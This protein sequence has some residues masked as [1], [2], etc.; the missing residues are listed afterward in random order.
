MS[1]QS[2]QEMVTSYRKKMRAKRGPKQANTSNKLIS[3]HQNQSFVTNQ[4]Y[5][6]TVQHNSVNANNAEGNLKPSFQY[7]NQ[8][9][10]NDILLELQRTSEEQKTR[11]QTLESTIDDLYAKYNEV[12]QIL[13]LA[14]QTGTYQYQYSNMYQMNNAIPVPQSFVPLS[15]PQGFHPVP[16]GQTIE[17]YQQPQ[18][19]FSNS[20]NNQDSNSNLSMHKQQIITPESNNDSSQNPVTWKP[21]RS[22]SELNQSVFHKSDDDSE[23]DEDSYEAPAPKKLFG[24]K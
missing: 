10:A 13:G 22:S 20:T 6:T 12:K 23:Y 19:Y 3:L 18:D 7:D 16:L 24:R 5:H 1:K 21:N 15:H 2:S 4:F 8:D 9:K 11:I 14:S 17:E